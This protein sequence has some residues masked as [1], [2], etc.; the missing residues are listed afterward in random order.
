MK[1]SVIG[2]GKLGACSAAC[3]AY[4]GYNVLGLDINEKFVAKINNKEA[5]VKEPMLDQL[6]KE[7]DNLKA[8]LSY[9]EIINN[10]DVTFLIVP[11]PSQ[12]NGH[13][14]NRFLKSAL[15]NLAIEFK[16]V[17]KFHI[18][19]ICSTVSPGAIN[20]ELVPFFEK[21]SNKKIGIDFGISYNPEFI[22]LG[23]VINDFLNPD[24]VLIGE[25][26][27]KTGDTLEEIYRKVC[28]NEPKISRMSIASSEITK[29]ALNSFVTMKI[30][31]AN[32]LANI[33][34]QVPNANIDDITS[35]IGSDKRVGL[36]Y[37]KGAISFGGPCFPRDNIAFSKFASE[38]GVKT[39]LAK[40]TDKVNNIQIE[41]LIK[42]ILNN[43]NNDF[44]ISI[45]GL[46]YKP[47]TPVI[48]E[49]PSLKIIDK[50]LKLRNCKIK[51]YDKLAIENVRKIY[52]KKLTYTD[53]LKEV[54][55]G[56]DCCIIPVPN[57]EYKEIQNFENLPKKIIDCWRILD[58][59]IIFSKTEYI[60]IGVY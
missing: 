52:G 34:E 33:T 39:P 56:S 13:Y 29:I 17:A 55:A 4:R 49:S 50:I 57:D 53:S 16:K 43:I 25:S 32:T 60:E 14:S 38:I 12:E 31:F 46:S 1:L 21:K 7:S 28:K 45:V 36:P 26:D 20:N 5:P 6:I 2:L 8:T 3:F 40:A 51:V 27:K 22:A 19:V 24:M 37:L 42:K 15:E 58:K 11:T 47:N 59:N 54:I 23:S 10:T 30:S 41:L 48:E 35:A 9:E 44:V 18:F